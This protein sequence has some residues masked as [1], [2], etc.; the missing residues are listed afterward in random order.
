M[1]YDRRLRQSEIEIIITV[2]AQGIIKKF[3]I[4]GR[5]HGGSNDSRLF[6]L[7]KFWE[8]VIAM[9]WLASWPDQN[10]NAGLIGRV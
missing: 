7:I 2:N 3:F 1:S 4:V 5:D 8:N 10:V 9:L 6:G